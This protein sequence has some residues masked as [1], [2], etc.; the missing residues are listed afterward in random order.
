MGEIRLLPAMT[1]RNYSLSDSVS[2]P[3]FWISVKREERLVD[4][5][6]DGLISNYLHNVVEE[7]HRIEL[8]P[9]CGEFTIDPTTVAKPIVLIAG[10]IGVTP[11]LSMAKSIN[12]AN[13][14]A[15]LTFIQAARNSKVQAFAGELRKLTQAGPNV[16]V[17]VIYDAPWPGDVEGGKCDETGL[18]TTDLLRDWTRYLEAD[19]YFCGPKPFMRNILTCLQELGVDEQRVHYEFFGPK[20]ELAVEPAAS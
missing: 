2:Q 4:G 1:P 20:E 19:Y 16:C 10:G 5:A 9:P 11:L 3:Y 13:P 8:G 18:I 7:G 17:K 6:P 14:H 12:Q 15:P